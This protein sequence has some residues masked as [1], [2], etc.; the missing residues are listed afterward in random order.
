MAI[1]SQSSHAKLVMQVSLLRRIKVD[2]MQAV[3]QSILIV[4]SL[5]F[6]CFNMFSIFAFLI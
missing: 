6:L 3:V 4:S 2:Q 1:H 5:D